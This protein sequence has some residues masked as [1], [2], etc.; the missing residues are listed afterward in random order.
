MRSYDHCYTRWNGCPTD[1]LYVGGLLNSS[2]ANANS[3]RLDRQAGRADVNV[4]VAS[5]EIEAGIGTQSGVIGPGAIRECSETLG[6]VVT[7][8]YVVKERIKTGG[9]VVV[10]GVTAKERISTSGRVFVAGGGT[11]APVTA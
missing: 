7:A 5:L 1:A 8:S 10:P 6:C 11:V 9:R 4:V 3:V 2:L